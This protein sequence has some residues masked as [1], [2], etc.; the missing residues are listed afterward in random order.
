MSD[1]TPDERRYFRHTR[2]GDRAY[3]VWREGIQKLRLDRGLQEIVFP[4]TDEWE[5][6]LDRSQFTLQQ[7]ARVAWAA[8]RQLL[9]ALSRY[10]EARLEWQNLPEKTR[11]KFVEQGPTDPKVHLELRIALWES[12][13]NV[14]RPL[15]K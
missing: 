4:R 12:M 3:L 14:L 10:Q 1:P 11:L 8:D 13:M 15:A 5:E 6:D 9:A 7:I 2:T